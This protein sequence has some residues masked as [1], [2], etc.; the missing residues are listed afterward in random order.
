MWTS[1]WKLWV[2]LLLQTLILGLLRDRSQRICILFAQLGYQRAEQ[3]LWAT[4]Q[5]C[6]RVEL[7]HA[8]I[9]HHHDAII[10]SNGVQTVLKSKSKIANQVSQ[11][12]WKYKKWRNI[13]NA[14]CDGEDGGVGK[15][16]ANRLLNQRITLDV[17][18]CSRLKI[19]PRMSH[20]IYK[21]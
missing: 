17:Y 21:Q 19:K 14:Y 13:L 12:D 20:S 18:R 3:G 10:I 7:A 11:I 1:A 9:A 8:S 6:R 2:L 16:G 15:V 5:R 4:Q